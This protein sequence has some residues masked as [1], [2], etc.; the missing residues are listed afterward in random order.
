MKFLKIPIQ[1]K[2]MSDIFHLYPLGD[3]HVGHKNTALELIKQTVDV[4]E[5]D[6]YARVIGMGDYGNT[7]IPG[8]K[9]FDFDTLDFNYPTPDTQ[10]KYVRQ[11][12]A[13]IKDKIDVLLTGNHDDRMAMKHSHNSV[14]EDVAD[15]LWDNQTDKWS[16]TTAY[17]RYI[18]I[19]NPTGKKGYG[20][21]AN[22]WTLDVFAHHGYAMEMR[23]RGSKTN[24]VM[25]MSNIFPHADIYLMGHLHM[26]DALKETPLRIDSN[27]KIVEMV[28]YYI[29]TGGFLRGYVEN[30]PSYVERKLLPPQALG[31]P[32]IAIRP[33]T[34]Q[35]QVAEVFQGSEKELIEE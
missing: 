2:S 14:K 19:R 21:E 30:N 6:K 11:Q 26:A 32:C 29:L 3:M 34:H 33:A 10:Y 20:N 28:K 22:S 24:R 15:K 16:Y 13:R 23:K 1:Y 18:F 5:K 27:G 8:D 9:F 4:I 12:F 7:E 25:E 17:I 35:I 31:S